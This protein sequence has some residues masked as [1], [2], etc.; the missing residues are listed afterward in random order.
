MNP[1]R[2]YRKN[3][4]VILLDVC[5]YTFQAGDTIYFTVKVKP[6]DDTTDGDALIKT[7]WTYGTD[8]DLDDQ[9]VLECTLTATETDID[10]GDYFYDIKLVAA[11]DPTVEQ[12]LVTG[13]FTVL[14]VA[15]LRV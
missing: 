10:F 13:D 8:V 4:F 2:C 3:T 7:S 12:T 11:S 15:T 14:P 5:D 6:D 9:G 1:L